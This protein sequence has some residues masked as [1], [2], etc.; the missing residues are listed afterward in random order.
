MNDAAAPQPYA[1][2]PLWRGGAPGLRAHTPNDQPTL[3]PYMPA[4][5]THTGAAMV[6]CPGG[7]YGHLAPHEGHDYALWLGMHGITC[8]VLRYRLGSDGYRHPAMLD[9]AARAV[10][11]VRTR[12]EEWTIDTTRI[13]IMGSSAGG[14]LAATLLTHYDLG[15][16][17]SPDPIDRES[18]RPD[19]GVLCYPVISMG[20]LA[21][22]GSKQNLLGDQP[23]VED[24][25]LLSNE[26]HV[27]PDT[28]PC[29]IWHTWED[30]E[31]KVE[32]S[33]E[34][35]AALRRSGVP[36]DL[37]IYERGRH[38]LGLDDSPPFHQV[39]PWANNLKAWLQLH[40]FVNA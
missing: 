7:G 23:S 20:P 15:R 18:S 12:A 33:L 22:E 10:R 3:T 19:L 38:G 35:A 37:H 40:G 14:H 30:P 11:M 31:V 39:H 5:H 36:F 34:F 16:A 21:H 17:D 13:G 6:I 29:F 24:V 32:N 4:S 26:R 25:H 28:P 27:T 9:D 8:F 2:I 1:A